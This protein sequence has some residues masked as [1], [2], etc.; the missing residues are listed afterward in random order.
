MPF[1]NSIR[2]GL[3]LSISF[4]K[5]LY[6]VQGDIVLNFSLFL[7]T[8]EFVAIDLITFGLNV[9]GVSKYHISRLGEGGGLTENAFDAYVF[10]GKGGGA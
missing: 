3:L 6:L 4:Q 9:L 8:P 1:Q 10:D 5:F 2:G 7:L